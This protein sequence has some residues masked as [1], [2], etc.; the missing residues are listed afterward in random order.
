MIP[1]YH[2]GTE[3]L[4]HPKTTDRYHS[5]IPRVSNPGRAGDE[6]MVMTSS[7]ERNKWHRHSQKSEMAEVQSACEL[8]VRVGS[9][10]PVSPLQK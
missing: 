3:L 1:L 2:G 7:T 10:F 4:Y 5:P 9:N 6:A 8:P